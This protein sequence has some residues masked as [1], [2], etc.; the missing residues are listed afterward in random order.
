[1]N[2]D[3]ASGPEAARTVAVLGGTGFLG[4]ALC[5]ELARPGR[6]VLTVSRG[7]RAGAPEEGFRR[8]DLSTVGVDELAAFLDAEAVTEVV[9][10][11]GGMWG[12][13][14]QQMLDANVTLVQT[15]IAAI[16][17]T[18]RKPRL[19]QMGSVHEYGL[20]PIGVSIAEDYPA[21]PVMAYGRLKLAA[22]EAVVEATERGDLD[23][24]VLRL[25]N[26]VGAGQPGHSLLGV[27]AEKLLA[28]SRAGTTAQLTLDP[29]TALRDF[30][31]L[32]DCVDATVL[33]LDAAAPARVV[34]IGRGIAAT[35]REL[36][37][38]LIAVSKVDTVVTENETGAGPETDWQQ[39]A[40][41]LAEE[42][43]GWTPQRS[44]EESLTDLWEACSAA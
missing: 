35:A 21:A 25:G 14:D 36:A 31:D 10:A 1:M 28:A 43:L 38:G 5:A 42:S 29:L 34:N 19:V 2:T 27:L 7:S 33:A 20:V 18:E 9:N 8:L 22:T 26:V 39:L 17:T 15:L 44:L 41:G 3:P 4:R 32:S 24:V 12:L 11:A 13:N 40:I 16:A 30:V 37:E 6:R 23:G